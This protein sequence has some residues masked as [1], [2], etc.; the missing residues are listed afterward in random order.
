MV[1]TLSQVWGQVIAAV[2]ADHLDVLGHF[3]HATHVPPHHDWLTSGTGFNRK[4]F[5][6]LWRAVVAFAAL[7]AVEVG[8]P[9]AQ[10]QPAPV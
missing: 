6:A 5:E 4:V 3:D 1:P 2:W 8:R 7:P 9:G 10:E